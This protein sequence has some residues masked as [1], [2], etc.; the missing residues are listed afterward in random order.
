MSIFRWHY[1]HL[2]ASILHNSKQSYRYQVLQRV[3]LSTGT[4]N[5]VLVPPSTTNWLVGAGAVAGG[6]DTALAWNG[7]ESYWNKMS[8][9]VHEAKES[10]E[11]TCEAE[12]RAEV[13]AKEQGQDNAGDVCPD[14]S[15]NRGGGSMPKPPEAQNDTRN[16]LNEIHEQETE[17]TGENADAITQTIEGEPVSQTPPREQ[18][19]RL[20][21]SPITYNTPPRRPVRERLGDRPESINPWKP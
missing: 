21:H 9:E 11:Q 7:M 12:F 4:R 13:E 18:I 3:D 19:N 2:F 1:I 14:L 8:Q 15:N 16:T 20:T 17:V 5:E 10:E 6:L